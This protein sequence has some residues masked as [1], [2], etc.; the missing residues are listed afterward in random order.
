MPMPGSSEG[1]IDGKKALMTIKTV[2]DTLGKNT[3]FTPYKKIDN[4]FALEPSRSTIDAIA[5]ALD[6]DAMSDD[7]Y[8]ELRK[9]FHATPL[10]YADT[11]GGYDIWMN[12][13]ESGT[14]G[15]LRLSRLPSTSYVFTAHLANTSGA[16][17]ASEIRK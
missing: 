17:F 4:S 5:K 7:S 3:L 15:E 12:V 11:T 1:K 10:W 9:N 6:T 16:T 2:L 13:A 8:L 14:S